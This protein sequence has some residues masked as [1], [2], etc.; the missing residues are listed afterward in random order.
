MSTFTAETEN[1]VKLVGARHACLTL[2]HAL[3]RKQ[4]QLL[5]EGNI[6][7]LLDVLSAKQR[8]LNDLGRIERAL[9]PFRE[10]DPRTRRWPSEAHRAACARQLE[11]CERL[12][13]DIVRQEKLCEASLVQQRD[14][15]AA[16]LQGFR[17]AGEA[18]GAYAAEAETPIHS[19][20]QLDLA[21][22]R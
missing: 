10:E 13:Q 22:E 11:E 4:K 9:D 6:T 20:N 1:L 15:A 8:P 7:A 5:D 3:G 14:E 18:V 2:L 12:L 16:R 21:S 19:I 17:L